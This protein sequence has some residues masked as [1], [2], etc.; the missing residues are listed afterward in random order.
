MADATEA[1][2]KKRILENKEGFAHI[3]NHVSGYR[4]QIPP[5]DRDIL[6]DA[7]NTLD[8]NAREG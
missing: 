8:V 7:D 1:K 4:D 2:E 5:P 3:V 6:C